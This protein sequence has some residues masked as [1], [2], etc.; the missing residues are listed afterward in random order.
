MRRPFPSQAFVDRQPV[1][2]PPLHPPLPRLDVER[3]SVRLVQRL[4]IHHTVIR[5]RHPAGPPVHVPKLVLAPKY[6]Q[7]PHQ[8]SRVDEPT[9]NRLTT[10]PLILESPEQ[11]QR[12]VPFNPDVESATL[13]KIPHLVAH[14]FPSSAPLYLDPP[15]TAASTAASTSSIA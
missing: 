7:K 11:R 9:P 14:L 8:K 10:P 15:F 3:P 1:G 5:V 6:R 13:R 2:K 12:P 4:H